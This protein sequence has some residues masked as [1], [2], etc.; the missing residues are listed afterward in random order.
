MKKQKQP[1]GDDELKQ[2]LDLVIYWLRINEEFLAGKD[3]FFSRRVS[4]GKHLLSMNT[5]FSEPLFYIFTSLTFYYILQ[6]LSTLSNLSNLST[7][8]TMYSDP[9]AT[10]SKKR[11]LYVAARQNEVSNL[12]LTI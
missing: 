6:H 12:N 11:A 2:N 1:V 7:S 10:K 9:N 4:K 8:S 3:V 5:R